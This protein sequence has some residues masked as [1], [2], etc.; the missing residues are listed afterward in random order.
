V[1]LRIAK[2]RLDPLARLAASVAVAQT[3]DGD[4]PRAREA[5][6]ALDVRASD[7]SVTI[8]QHRSGE[9]KTYA[10]TVSGL[11]NGID[12]TPDGLAE[13]WSPSLI[14]AQLS[15]PPT[16]VS[17]AEM[18]ERQRA[19]VAD[20]IRQRLIVAAF[21]DDVPL[22]EAGKTAELL[23]SA[24]VDAVAELGDDRSRNLTRLSALLDLLEIERLHVPFNA[25]TRFYDAFLADGRPK[26]DHTLAALAARLGF[27]MPE[28]T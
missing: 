14:S 17:L 6:R 4:D 2:P 16:D 24:V 8:H 22:L 26:L 18:T 10:V 11:P 21:G 7:G 27:A 13:G 15:D 1:Y 9:E 19:V 25:Q 20:A 12:A 5:S 23:S 28:H 3:I